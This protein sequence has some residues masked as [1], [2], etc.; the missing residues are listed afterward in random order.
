MCR[1]WI[2]H[3]GIFTTGFANESETVTTS[4]VEGFRIQKRK[5]QDGTASQPTNPSPTSGPALA[6][7]PATGIFTAH[8]WSSRKLPHSEAQGSRRNRCCP[9]ETP[10]ALTRALIE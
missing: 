7:G 6:P 1:I 8:D 4:P 2:C 3:G 10:A 9:Y 5:A